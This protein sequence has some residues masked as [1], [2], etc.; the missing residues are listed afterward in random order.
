MAKCGCKKSLSEVQRDEPAGPNIGRRQVVLVWGNPSRQAAK[1]SE[2]VRLLERVKA[3]VLGQREPIGRRCFRYKQNCMNFC[4]Q[5][6]LG[7]LKK[8]L[9]RFHARRG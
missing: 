4:G 5:R 1:D 9:S 8:L 3:R 7:K 2:V 6:R